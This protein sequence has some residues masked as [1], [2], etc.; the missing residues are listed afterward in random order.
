MGVGCIP[1]PQK[2]DI[3]LNEQ[4]RKLWYWEQRPLQV[5]GSL[6]PPQLPTP[7]LWSDSFLSPWSSFIQGLVFSQGWGTAHVCRVVSFTTWDEETFFAPAFPC[8]W[9]SGIESQS[10]LDIFSPGLPPASL[11]PSPLARPCIHSF[12]WS[13]IIHY[14]GPRIVWDAAVFK[15]HW[16]SLRT[17]FLLIY[18]SL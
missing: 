5:A 16:V 4:T 18:Y 10:L 13:I 1:P 15:G 9:T 11:S 6:T 12:I 7:L 3:F 8:T 17:Y 14:L 2:K